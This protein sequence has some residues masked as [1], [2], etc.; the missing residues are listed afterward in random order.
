MNIIDI[1]KTFKSDDQCTEYLAKLRWPDGVR[2]LTCGTD[3]VKQYSS[4][5]KKQPSRK[6]YECQEPTCK[7]QFTATSGTI[8]HDTHLPL[9]KW[10]LALSIL[11]DAKKSVSAKQLQRHLG[12][13]Y[14]TAWYLAHRIRKAMEESDRP[15]LGGIVEMDETYVGG[16]TKS[17]QRYKN[18]DVVVGM[19]QRGGQL[20]LVHA[21]DSTAFT[22]KEIAEG[23]ISPDVEALMT[24]ELPAYKTSLEK[25]SGK[26]KQIRHKDK[27][28]VLAG[29]IHTNTIESAFSLFKRGIVGSFHRVSIKHLQRYLNEFQFRFNRRDNANR[30][31]ETLSRMARVKPMPFAEL[32]QPVPAKSV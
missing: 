13:G 4:P 20:H 27:V 24:D 15:L 17:W 2:C 14:K 28:Y 8:F 31:E 5:T 18:K 16:R 12:T 23:H 3:K 19:R 26:H 10:F 7:Q 30:F 25:F 9:T 22:L 21:P 6:V 1:H 29:N 11:V 32:T